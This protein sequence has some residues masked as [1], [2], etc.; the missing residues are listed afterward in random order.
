[1]QDLIKHYEGDSEVAFVAI[2]TAFEGFSFNDLA[3]AKKTIKRYNLKIPVGHSGSSEK[4]SRFMRNFRT[5]GTP[6]VVIIDKKGV[7]R[8][9]HFH[10]EVSKTIRFMDHLKR[11]S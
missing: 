2:Q 3:G 5:R 4:P 9:N 11:E 8:F 1:M 6:W 7:V 10:Q